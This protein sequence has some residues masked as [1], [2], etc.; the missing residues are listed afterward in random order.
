[1]PTI[2][3]RE[4][5]CLTGTAGSLKPHASFSNFNGCCDVCNG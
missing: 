5:G 3:T 2:S 1:M 4:A